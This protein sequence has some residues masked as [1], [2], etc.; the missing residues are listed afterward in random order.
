MSEILPYIFNI[1]LDTYLAIVNLLYN[2][3]F[4]ASACLFFAII[5]IICLATTLFEK[6]K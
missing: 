3:Y 2:H 5:W 6:G 4:T 1:M